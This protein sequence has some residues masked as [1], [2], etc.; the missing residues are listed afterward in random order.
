MAGFALIGSIIYMNTRASTPF[1]ALESEN[2]T[3]TSPATKVSDTTASAGSA[4][5]FGQT[6]TSPPNSPS[7]TCTTTMAS[8]GNINTFINSLSAGAVGCIPGGVYTGS[9]VEMTRSGSSASRIVVQSVPGQTA[10]FKMRLSVT[11]AFVTFRSLNFDTD[12]QLGTSN[13]WVKGTANN[14]TFEDNEFADSGL[15]GTVAHDGQCLYSDAPSYNIHIVRNYF[16]DC[17][18][19]DHFHHSVYVSGSNFIIAN[20]LFVRTKAFAIHLYPSLK[21]S[22]ITQNTID[23]SGRSGV[24]IAENSNGNRVVNN[25]STNNAHFGYEGYAVVGTNYV[26]D[27]I[28]FG[29]SLGCV[30]SGNGFSGSNNLNVDPLYVNRSGG[31]Y[32]VNTGSP[33]IN[34]A[35]L[36][37]I[38]SPDKNGVARP[39][40]GAFDKGAYER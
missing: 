29:N 36:S 20:N 16:H 12:H 27:N 23:G 31:D 32:R 2:G 4:I 5:K 34:S 13:V 3:L 17:G 22:L 24:I 30:E 39:Q 37:Y 8:G 25:I 21:N 35:N 1:I 10:K 15:S 7:P 11:S 26:H 18:S 38:V 14:I 33:A 19:M 6:S 9:N 40:G 28:C